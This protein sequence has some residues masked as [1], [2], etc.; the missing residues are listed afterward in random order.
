MAQTIREKAKIRQ[1]REEDRASEDDI[2]RARLGPQG[3]K[4]KPDTGTMTEDSKLESPPPV[5]PGHT[6]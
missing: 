1:N 3:Q 2:S 5:D 4:D 6:A